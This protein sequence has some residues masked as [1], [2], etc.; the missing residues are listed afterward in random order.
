[1]QHAIA[2]AEQRGRIEE[3][4]RWLKAAQRLSDE[5]DQVLAASSGTD[6]DN[7]AA[8]YGR[9]HFVW[10][11]AYEMLPSPYVDALQREGSDHG[12]GQVVAARTTISHV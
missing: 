6:H 2:E 7:L 3:R 4:Q 10:A 8:W 1:V 9:K 11:L 5:A 12:N